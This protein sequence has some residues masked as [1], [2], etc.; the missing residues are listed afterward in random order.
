MKFL[1]VSD[2][3]PA[4]DSGSAGSII[5]IG[6]AL[7]ARGHDVDYEWRSATPR[8]VPH[9][10]ASVVLELPRIQM[11]QV[12]RRLGGATYDVVVASQPYAYLMY[13]RL[14]GLHTR[15]VFLN[16]THGWEDRLYAAYRRFK[17]GPPGP[18][19]RRAGSYAAERAIHRACV[20]TAAAC[21]GLIAP[22]SRCAEFVRTTYGMAEDKVAVV[23][24]GVDAVFLE[25]RRAAP[26]P[27]RLRLLYVGHYLPGKGSAVLEAALPSVARK[28]ADV[29]LTL[30]VDAAS[31]EAVRRR[32]EPDFGERLSV[33]PWTTRDQLRGV[34]AEHDVLLHPSYFEGFGKAWQEAMACG[35]CV[36]AFGEGGLPDVASDGAEALFSEVGDVRAYRKM[37]ERCLADPA[38]ARS[39]GNRAR[40]AIS[41]YT[42]D[43]TAAMTEGFCER[44]RHALV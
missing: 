14:Q 36:V 18:V 24:Y 12:A 44:R 22:S 15:T 41:E 37:L 23:P 2:F 1:F 20:R 32:Y 7:A 21:Q 10:T 25:Q 4:P 28:H 43:R 38:M 17:W 6:D 39:V 31:V 42:W 5:A 8:R 40:A 26:P 33:L 34:Y 16:R 13:E 3:L 30:V 27:D 11:R 19:W 29:R 9:H 35:L